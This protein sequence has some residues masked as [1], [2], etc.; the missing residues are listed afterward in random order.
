MSPDKVPSEGCEPSTM[1]H[2]AELLILHRIIGAT[3]SGALKWEDEDVHG[4]YSTVLAGRQIV[5]RLLWYE[6]TNQIGAD[7]AV[8]EFNMP[9][10]DSKFAFG[11]QGADLLFDLLATAFPAKWKARE[12][13]FATAFLD[14][15][16]GDK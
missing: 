5:F 7:P 12:L 14:E 4:W 3:R 10:W 6:A 11:T 16:L 9:G 2:D 15:H 1:I 8:F 13:A